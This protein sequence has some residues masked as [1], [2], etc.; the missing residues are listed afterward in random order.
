MS[1]PEGRSVPDSQNGFPKSL[2]TSPLTLEQLSDRELAIILSIEHQL[3]TKQ[4]GASDEGKTEKPYLAPVQ[5][6]SPNVLLLDG[7]RGT[8][9][10]SLLLTMAHRWNVHSICGVERHDHNPEQYK[11]RIKR[12]QCVQ[13]ELDGNIPKQFHPLRILDFDPIPPQMSLISGIVHAWQPLAA[14]YDKST[15][16]PADCDPEDDTLEDRWEKL[17]RVA[18]VGWSPVPAAKGL[19]EQVLDRQEQ[20]RDWQNVGHRWYEFVSE[21]I[22][23]GKRL[24]D[25]H[26]LDWAPIF[27][28]MIDDVD[29]QVERIR[30]VLPALR[31]LYHPNVAFLVAA[32]WDHLIDTLKI[33]FLGKQNRL[34]NRAPNKNALTEADDDKWAGTLAFAAVTKVFPRKNKWTLPKLSL[35]ELLA[36]PAS[37]GNVVDPEEADRDTPSTMRK[38]LNEWPENK[39]GYRQRDTSLGDYLHGIATHKYE[40]PSLISYREAHQIFERASMLRNDGSRAIEAVRLLVSDPEMEAVTLDENGEMEAHVEYRRSG[41]LA[42]LFPSEHLKTVSEL[43]EIVLGARPQFIFLREPFSDSISSLGY[44]GPA[45]NF[46]SAMLAL[47]IQDEGFGVASPSLQ[48][49]VRLALAWTRVRVMDENSFLNLSFHW[50]FHKHPHPFQLLEWG[51]EW[52]KFVRD[53]QSSGEDRLERIAYGWVYYQLKWMKSELKNIPCPLRT[54]ASDNWNDLFGKLV[55]MEPSDEKD[56]ERELRSQDWR[57]QTLPLLARPE[58]GLPPEVQC[59]LLRFVR[60]EPDQQRQDRQREW[61]KDQRRRLVTDAIIAAGDENRRREENP[62]NTARVDR[63]VETLRNGYAVA[64]NKCSPWYGSIEDPA[65]GAP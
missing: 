52:R 42:A 65:G 1:V 11:R 39:N 35:R 14:Q 7:A 34:A 4:K 57:T 55:E 9:K 53:I 41:E 64:Y 38:I 15:R 8:G 16:F 19:L 6:R 54:M 58:I 51:L 44:D 36:F 63:I 48:W 47:T 61:L 32:H 10:T 60:C 2:D 40:I 59:Q 46:T 37:G 27:V 56:R 45:I 31:L 26:R 12:I 22:R 30:E 50:R 17:F 18:T 21:V 43:S 62:E 3:R 20:V 5:V 49:N 25:F 29:L 28:I 23:R 13:P 33:D 24:K